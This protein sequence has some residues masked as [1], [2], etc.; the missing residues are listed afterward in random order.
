[1]QTAAAKI[2]ENK[3]ICKEPG[4]YLAWPTIGRK[5]DGELLVVFSGDREAHRCPYG[6]NQMIRSQDSGETWSDPVTINNSPMDDRDTGLLVTKSGTIVISW[7]TGESRSNLDQYWELIPDHKLDSWRRHVDKLT[8]ETIE[9][10]HGSWT[11]RS[12]DDGVSW[13]SAVHSIGKTPHGPIQLKDGRLLFVGITKEKD[14]GVRTLVSV[15]STDDAQS[16]RLIGTVPVPAEHQNDVP[17]NEPHVVEL[18]NGNLVSMWRFQPNRYNY[19]NHT[20]HIDTKGHCSCGKDPKEHYMQ[21]SESIDGGF[22][23]TEA[24]PTPI[25]GYP[26]HLIRLR[27]D[28]LLATY[29]VRQIPY[30]QRACL[31][32][33]GGETWD[34]DNE[35]ILRDD[36]PD[37]NLGYPATIELNSGEFLTVY[38]QAEERRGKTCIMATRWS[39]SQ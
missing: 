18:A 12:T 32:V 15:E 19:E 17:Y 1:M 8:E 10:W 30:G 16:W 39:L 28:S 24:H 34:I 7:F 6:K 14:L 29:G 3:V 25:W 11:R 21:Q 35:I 5:T 27:N 20:C 9:R 38:Y 37:G 36:G 26:P 13:E 22:T 31:S 23:W 4:N 2:H 33:D